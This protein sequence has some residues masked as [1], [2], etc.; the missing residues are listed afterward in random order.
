MPQV[1]VDG[2][3]INLSH[4]GL[5]EDPETFNAATLRFLL[6]QPA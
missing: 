2:L 5:H 1:D 4:A 3:T 6:S